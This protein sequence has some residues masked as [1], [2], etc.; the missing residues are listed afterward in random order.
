VLDY[1]RALLKDA[2][3]ED[4]TVIAAIISECCDLRPQEAIEEIKSAYK[5][6]IVDK[7]KKCC[8]K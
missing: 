2:K 4:E 6:R 1:F 7:Y 8:G 5:K 3:N